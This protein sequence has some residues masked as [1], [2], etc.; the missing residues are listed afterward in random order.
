MT[1]LGGAMVKKTVI[2]LV[3][4]LGLL[5]I[6]VP[7]SFAGGY[8]HYG[9]HFGGH[10]GNGGLYAAGAIVG[11]LLLGSVIA[12]AVAPPPPQPVYV[13]PAPPDAYDYGAPAGEWVIVPGRWLNGRWIPSHRVW[14]PVDPY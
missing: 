6:S 2:I 4:I 12:A 13:Y 11:G 9:R 1:Y 3:V 7:Q 5:M 10:Y 14:V 8:G